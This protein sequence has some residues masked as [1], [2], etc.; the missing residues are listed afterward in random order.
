MWNLVVEQVRHEPADREVNHHSSDQ[1]GKFD[2]NEMNLL[3]FLWKKKNSKTVELQKIF[4]YVDNLINS[5]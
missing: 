4:Y 3:L 2:H 5:W 1:W